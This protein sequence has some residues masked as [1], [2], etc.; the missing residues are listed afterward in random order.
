MAYA[1][2]DACFVIQMCY[3][4]TSLISGIYFFFLIFHPLIQK[5]SCSTTKTKGT[6]TFT[7]SPTMPLV[8]M[9][10]QNSTKR[11][12]WQNMALLT[13]PLH[14]SVSSSVQGCR[15]LKSFACVFLTPCCFTQHLVPFPS[16]M[17]LL[18]MH[19]M[20]IAWV[21]AGSASYCEICL[22]EFQTEGKKQLFKDYYFF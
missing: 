14:R 17:H 22:Y 8:I 10:C 15:F 7:G 13:V 2:S 4:E 21:F 19:Q 5:K 18:D 9:S 16:S 3:L 1:N 20:A 6:E 11:I 12:L